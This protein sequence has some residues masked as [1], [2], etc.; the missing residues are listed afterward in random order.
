MHSPRHPPQLKHQRRVTAER[1]AA[2][3]VE[4][5]KHG[6]ATAAARAASPHASPKY[7]CLASFKEARR[8]DPQFCTQWDEAV[9]EAAARIE[10]ELH[11]RAVEGWD[12]P[13]F[14]KGEMV[15]TIKRY[16]D[17]LLEILA[18]GVRPDK[19]G[20][21]DVH[22][23]GAVQHTMDGALVLRPEDL[24]ALRP[25][26][27]RELVRILELV[28]D[29]RGEAKVEHVPAVERVAL[30]DVVPSP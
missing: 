7:G 9:E 12:E 11:R 18:K 5:R 10:G 21:T 6:I 29:S 14:Q 23:T 1:K 20:R 2:F 17:R 25:P 24:L 16:S 4:L 8:R 13:V 30:L 15:G 22:V 27:R 28:A 3:I 26:D 19:Y